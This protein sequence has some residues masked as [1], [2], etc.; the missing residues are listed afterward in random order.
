MSA[1]CWLI[2]HTVLAGALLAAYTI[3]KLCNK[4]ISILIGN[5][6]CLDVQTHACMIITVSI[7]S[8]IC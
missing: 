2:S 7:R 3:D 4:S 6:V 8:A 5:N 1:I